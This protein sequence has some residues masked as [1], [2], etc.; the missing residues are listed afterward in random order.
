MFYERRNAFNKFVSVSKV[1]TLT[2]N[3]TFFLMKDSKWYLQV[4]TVII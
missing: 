2:V 4:C 3:E 1:S